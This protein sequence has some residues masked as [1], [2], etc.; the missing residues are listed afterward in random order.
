MAETGN[1]EVALVAA[2]LVKDAGP[3]FLPVAQSLYSPLEQAAVVLKGSQNKPAAGAFLEF[4]LT[5][6]AQRILQEY[7]FGHP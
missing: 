7:G 2:A 3:S 4:L 6:E 5:A 1:A